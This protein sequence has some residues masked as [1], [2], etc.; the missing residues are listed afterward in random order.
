MFAYFGVI[1]NSIGAIFDDSMSGS[2]FSQRLLQLESTLE[3]LTNS[4]IWG[5][6]IKGLEF[7]RSSKSTDVLGAESVWLQQLIYFGLLGVVQ[8]LI[9]YISCYK[10][11]KKIKSLI[12]LLLGWIAFS[13]MSSSPGLHETYFLIILILLYKTKTILANR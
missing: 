9:L 6:G 7:V 3:V 11:T 10:L 8:Q 13:T 5:Y 1:I 12:L 2:N 4:L